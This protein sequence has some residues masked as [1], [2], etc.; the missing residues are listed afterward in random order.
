M[1]LYYGSHAHTV[2]TV[3]IAISKQR[4]RTAAEHVWAVRHRWDIT[5]LVVGTGAADIDTKVR[6]LE[7]AWSVDGRDVLLKL[8]D[9]TNS[10]HT[11]ESSDCVGG[12]R[13][14]MRSFPRGRGAE[15]VTHRTV[16]VAVEGDVAIA[17]G[18]LLSQLAAFNESIVTSGGGRRIGHLTV[19]RGRPHAQTLARHT[20]FRA[21]QSGSAVGI[22][23]YPGIPSP[24]WPSAQVANPQIRRG[25]PRRRQGSYVDYPVTWSYQFESAYPL[26]GSPNIW[27][28]SYIG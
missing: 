19:R 15:G 1:Q 2:G 28:V 23:A 27:G 25:T 18:S 11:L 21:V 9:G 17:V 3:E 6:T 7:S 12:T 22:Y 16:R 10:T 26:S 14:V 4:L 5:I 20:P 24:I 8:P 13:V